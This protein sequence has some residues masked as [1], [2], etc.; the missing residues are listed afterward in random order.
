MPAWCQ[1]KEPLLEVTPNTWMPVEALDWEGGGMA[2]PA[3]SQ[4]SKRLN[5]F[6]LQLQGSGTQAQTVL[7]QGHVFPECRE[8]RSLYTCREVGGE[9]GCH[10]T[11]YAQG[12]AV[13]PCLEAQGSPTVEQ[14]DLGCDHVGLKPEQPMLPAH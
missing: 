14:G 4:V 9:G 1:A 5:S 2:P 11:H 12:L 8:V 3:T 7:S 13:C 6:A 10:D